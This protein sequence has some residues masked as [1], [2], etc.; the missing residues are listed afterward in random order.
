MAYVTSISLGVRQETQAAKAC[1]FCVNAW[2]LE[3]YRIVSAAFA[4]L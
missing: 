3:S 2:W 4:G 1:V